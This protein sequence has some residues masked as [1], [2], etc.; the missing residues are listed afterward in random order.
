MVVNRRGKLV[1]FT[2]PASPC[3]AAQSLSCAPLVFKAAGRDAGSSS[4]SIA[5]LCSWGADPA[6]PPLPNSLPLIARAGAEMLLL[7]IVGNTNQRGTFCCSCLHL[8][9][10]SA[11][12]QQIFSVSHPSVFPGGCGAF[13]CSR[14]GTTLQGLGLVRKR[15]LGCESGWHRAPPAPRPLR[16][17]CP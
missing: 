14:T 12:F 8:C 2:N 9:F 6:S 5:L 7:I 3:P 13:P 17:R 16:Q 15:L 10:L 11:S 1:H 4:S